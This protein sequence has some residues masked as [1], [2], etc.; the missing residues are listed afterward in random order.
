MKCITTRQVLR[1]KIPTCQFLK[2]MFDNG[3][4][5]EPVFY[6]A[7]DFE[8]KFM[9]R[10]RFAENYAFKNHV[11]FRS[12]VYKWESFADF[13]L[14]KRLNLKLKIRFCFSIFKI[15]Q[16]SNWKVYNISHFELKNLDHIRFW[17]RSSAAIRVWRKHFLQ[18]ISFR[19]L[20]FRKSDSFWNFGTV[21]KRMILVFE[22]DNVSELEW[23][24]F[25]ARRI[26]IEKV[27]NN[28]NL[29]KTLHSI[30]QFSTAFTP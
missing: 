17:L 25:S 6:N 8:L 3:A 21:S 20:F 15:C 28:Q 10:F 4:D 9:H 29:K 2:G 24:I 26:L 13:V 14:L 18:Q 23:N 19:L 7:S 30:D 12:T 27:E 22:D 11:L 16:I 5:L 1:W